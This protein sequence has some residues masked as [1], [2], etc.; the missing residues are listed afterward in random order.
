M[1]VLHVITGLGTGGA[2]AMLLKLAKQHQHHNQF[3]VSLTQGGKNKAL[4]EALGIDVLELNLKQFWLLPIRI[5]QV[6]SLIKKQKIDVINAWMYHAMLFASLI[7]PF[8]PKQ[9]KL[10]WN[11]RHSLQDIEQE[12]RS[13]KL[14][15]RLLATLTKRANAVIFNSQNSRKEHEKIWNIEHTACF[16][17]NGFECEQWPSKASLPVGQANPLFELLGIDDGLVIGHVGRAHPMKNHQGLIDA[18]L[19]V[20]AQHLNIHLVLIGKG[21][22]SF[23]VPNHEAG[24]RIHCLGERKDVSQLM[25]YF[26]FF[27]LSSNWGEGFPNVLGEAMLCALPSITTDVGDSKYLLNNDEWVIPP[28]QPQQLTQLLAKLVSLP[29]EQRSQLGE[30]YRQRVLA[31]FSIKFVGRLYDALYLQGVKG[32]EG[33]TK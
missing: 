31:R 16:L 19:D 10:F 5:F 30:S 24:I 12:K 23:S 21:T 14:I 27:V 22:E 7:L 28:Y 29:V 1:N 2:E 4:I 18:F 26:D 15:I 3:V 20:A 32:L 25:P 11:V 9:L 17:P 13:L 33:S 6:I 8:A